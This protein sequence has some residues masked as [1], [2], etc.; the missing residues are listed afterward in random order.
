MSPISLGADASAQERRLAAAAARLVRARRPVKLAIVPGPAGSPSLQL[1]AR[2]LRVRLS[3]EGTLVVTT[4]KG[5]IVATGPRPTP[6][7]RRQLRAERVIRITD[8]VVRLARA[9]D[10]VAP[11]PV[12]L[13]DAARR[14]TLV[15][16][17]IAALGGAWAA[18][19][20]IGRQGRRR[21]REVADARSR[22]RVCVDALRSHTLALAA[23]PDLAPATRRHVQSALGVY[24]EAISGLPEMRRL[25]Q[26]DALAPKIRSALDEIAAATA[27]ATGAPARSDPFEG[28][29]ATDPAHGVAAAADAG[30]A[31]CERCRDALARGEHP[32]PRMLFE[33]DHAVSFDVAAYGPI[34]RPAPPA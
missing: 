18:A 7:M 5:E 6:E 17:L 34:L 32:T 14:S 22:A 3:Y 30:P 24:A 9:A 21:R 29:C 23:R 26:V 2:R 12:N 13:A 10:L 25:E 19:L 15:L 11:P 28:L 1:Y 33:A 8:P 16:I 27:E 20:G 31:Y 4:P